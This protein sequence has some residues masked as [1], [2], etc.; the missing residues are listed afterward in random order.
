[1]SLKIRLSCDLRNIWRG[2]GGKAFQVLDRVRNVDGGGLG[3]S[4]S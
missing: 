3:G 2:P 4:D 1:M